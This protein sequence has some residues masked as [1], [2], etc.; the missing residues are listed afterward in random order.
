MQDWISNLGLWP[1]MA[2]GISLG[3]LVLFAAFSVLGERAL[4]ENADTILDER[5]IIA[6]MVAAQFDGLLNQAV[7]N[8]EQARNL[9]DFDPSDPDFS[10]E[11]LVLAH[12]YVQA[13]TTASGIVFMDERGRTLLT[14]PPNLYAPGTDLS[15]L[16][17][18]A[19]ALTLRA[20]TISDPFINSFND[21]VVAAVT[22]T[23]HDNGQ[24]IGL[25]TGL[26]DLSSPQVQTPL[27]EAA[28]MG[29]TGHALLIDKRGHVLASTVG[30]PALSP[31]EHATFYRQV[32]DRGE[33][34]VRAVPMELPDADGEIGHEHVMAVAP[35]QVAPW[36]VAV[37]SDA[38]ET[39]SGLGRLRLGLMLLAILTLAG[40]WM[41]TLLGT[42]R[43]VRPVQRLTAAAQRIADGDLE[44]PLQ[45][46]EGG[47]IGAMASALERM[48]IQLL[49]SIAELGT[50]NENLE[51]RV[52]ER[53]QALQR[54]QT[55]AQQLLRQAIAAQEEER[56]RLAR[57]LHDEIGQILTAVQLNV[58]RLS[59]TMPAAD[60]LAH[61]RLDRVQ[62]LT[63]QALTDLRRIMTAL[64]PGV[65]DQ[66]GLV[67][68][69]GWVADHT[70]RPLGLYVTIETKGL[71]KRLPG[72]LETILFRIA[73]EAMSN[74]ARHS[75]ATHLAIHLVQVEGKAIMT[76]TDD[77]VGFHP[78]GVAATSQEGGGLGLAGMQ[79]RA[80]LAGGQVT[81]ESTP[82]QGTEVR[83]VVPVPNL[84]EDVTETE[85][86]RQ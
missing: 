84:M 31:G 61:E 49:G 25:L 40:T 73:Q 35:L 22:V 51:T 38:D 32:L 43:L 66:L 62:Q 50:L 48:R 11:T 83:V 20:A 17:H 1:R 37:G 27:N 75:N 41:I 42:R 65:L 68:A 34:A 79:E 6:R 18:V 14:H 33:P 52:T 21:Q 55:L 19:Q 57:E 54:Q 80:S 47:E 72:E 74:I 36:A 76:L 59:K 67:P 82:G 71:E 78:A 69:L 30:A 3:F 64:R 12:V 56:A 5:L 4:H 7:S 45:T 77:G 44:T 28:T 10:E 16:P 15:T 46:P 81:I 86:Q 23:V 70:L 53:T 39:F 2:L 8:L 24:L 58:E 26:F 63:V 60:I 9:A 85:E 13:G 29:E